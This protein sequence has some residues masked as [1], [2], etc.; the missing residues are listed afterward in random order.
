VVSVVL[1]LIAPRLLGPALMVAAA[2]IVKGYTDVGDGFSAGVIVGTAVA[3]RYVVLGPE[4]AEHE[5]PVL[6]HAPRI[7][8]AGLLLALAVGFLGVVSGD[9]PFTHLPSPDGDVVKLGTLE[10]IT[11]VLFDVGVFM[12]VTA[13][14]IVLV[15]HLARLVAGDDG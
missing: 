2:I 12:L 6:R 1:E 7:L 15:H 9:P 4:R 14:L 8:V 3:L 5:L 13:S 10:L 11:A